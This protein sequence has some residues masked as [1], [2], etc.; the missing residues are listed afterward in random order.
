M[1]AAKATIVA[2]IA[3]TVTGS[4]GRPAV[5]VTLSGAAGTGW[6]TNAAYSSTPRGGSVQSSGPGV[7]G[8]ATAPAGSGVA[9]WAAAI[10]TPRS[11]S[12]RARTSKRARGIGDSFTG[13]G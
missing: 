3:S 2:V 4:A 7:A 6:P 8:R 10:R 11:E 13:S 9:S 5:I 12:M 1:Q